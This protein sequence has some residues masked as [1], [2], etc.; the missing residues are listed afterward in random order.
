[1]DPL[2]LIFLTSG[3]CLGWALGAND[4]ANVFGT[5]V[6][7][8]M[9]KWSTAAIICSI[10]VVL[11]AVISGS[12]T[13][14]TLGELG[15]ISALPSAFMTAL[16][17]AFAVYSMTK[18]GIPVSSSQ[19]I[20]GAII[21]WN[22]FSGNATDTVV[23]T[24]IL[25]S[26]VI[27]PILSGLIAVFIFKIVRFIATRAAIH[28]IM[29]DAY[30]RFAL[31]A[32]GA[33]GAYTLGANNIANVVGVFVPVQPLPN[34]DLFGLSISSTHQLFL[35]G[36]LSIA[37][38]VFSF[39]KKVMMTVGNDLGR[40]SST[41]A[42]IVVISH[43]IVLFLFAS[44]GLENLLLEFGLPSFPLVPVSSSQAVVGAVVGIS[45]LQGSLGV[46]WFVLGKII[47][48]WVLTPLLACGICFLG[49][50]FLQNVFGMQV[51]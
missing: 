5:A 1:M 8:K 42:L 20:V 43:S 51:I 47:Y 14:E 10:F 19:A 40:L 34:I 16:A 31:I 11:G 17:A 13:T 25:S 39:S 15:A 49:L 28:I 41:T 48:G 30:K 45:I 23:L 7:T 32:A 6:G 27:C 38:G 24:K 4:A 9:L 35:L 36:G 29:A 12:G 21:G 46:K 44:R 18:A 33:L 2:I 26:W 22:F 37:L 3:L 50:F